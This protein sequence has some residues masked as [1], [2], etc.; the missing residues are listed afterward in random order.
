MGKLIAIII[1]V[2]IIA[3]ALNSCL[4]SEAHKQAYTKGFSDTHISKYVTENSSQK[5][6]DNTSGGVGQ[7]WSTKTL[8]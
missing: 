8:E 6:Q 2:V 4:G 5:L 7:K 3:L 1:I